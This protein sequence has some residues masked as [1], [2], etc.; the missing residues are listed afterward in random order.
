MAG[1]YQKR[2]VSAVVAKETLLT[3]PSF[4]R[5]GGYVAMRH[6]NLRDLN[7]EMQREV[8]RDVV[9]EPLLLPFDSEDVQGTRGDRSAPD[10][11][12]R[13]GALEQF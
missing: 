6:N 7:A 4:A 10:I 1:E 8:C 12:S 2:Q 9:V 11:S 5:K 13:G 3:T